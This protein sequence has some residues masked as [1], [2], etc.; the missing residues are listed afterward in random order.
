MDPRGIPENEIQ[1]VLE[2]DSNSPKFEPQIK[3][4]PKSETTTEWLKNVKGH[5][6]L[7]GMSRPSQSFLRHLKSQYHP[8]PK[9]LFLTS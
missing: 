1:S 9:N 8:K 2:Y 3:T 6:T 7:F 5:T 4:K